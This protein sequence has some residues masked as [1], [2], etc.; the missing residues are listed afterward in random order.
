[1]FAIIVQSHR[2]Q[3]IHGRYAQRIQKTAVTLIWIL[4]MGFAKNSIMRSAKPVL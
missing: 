4:K 1:M 3:H 2:F